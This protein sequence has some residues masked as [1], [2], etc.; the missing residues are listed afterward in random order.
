MF[1]IAVSVNRRFHVRVG[2]CVRFSAA[3]QSS[4]ATQDGHVTNMNKPGRK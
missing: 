4:A 1:H 3:R 2:F